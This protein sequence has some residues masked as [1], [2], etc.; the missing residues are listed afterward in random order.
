MTQP[1]QQPTP[2]PQWAAYPSLPPAGRNGFG[3]TALALALTGLVFGLVPLTGF[4][5]L[6]LGALA[7]LFGLLGWARVR[8]GE[9]TNRK[10]TLTSI[11]VGVLVAALGIW[12]ISITFNAVDKFGKDLQGIGQGSA[13]AVAVPSVDYT[14][15]TPPP[16]PSEFVIG[17]QVLQKQCFGTAGCNIT[18]HINPEYVGSTPISGRSLTVIYEVTGGKDGP[19]INNFTLSGDG[20]ATYPKHEFTSTSSS[21]VTLTAKATSVSPD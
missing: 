8:R 4:L 3:I 2:P 20:T 11:A 21:G 13:P 1:P 6:I 14:N 16:R 17:V 19:Q 7:V 18:Y 12:G 10:M 5:A 9:A 15:Q